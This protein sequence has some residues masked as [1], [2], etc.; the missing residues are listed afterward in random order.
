MKK[1]TVAILTVLAALS[2]PVLAFAD[3]AGVGV[4]VTLGL[5]PY[6]LIAAVVVTV[7][8]ILVKAIRRRKNK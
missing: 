2:F 1:L 7:I 6:I 5:L 3:I 4:V 8:V